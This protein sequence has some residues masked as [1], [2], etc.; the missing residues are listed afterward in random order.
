MSHDKFF[1]ICEN[2]CLVEIN[3]DSVG[4]AAQDLSNIDNKVFAE[5]A[6]E[7]GVGGGGIGSEIVP[8]ENGGTGATTAEEARI[9]LGINSG[10]GTVLYS[11]DVI[12]KTGSSH[13]IT[14]EDDIN[15]YKYIEVC[16]RRLYQQIFYTDTNHQ[17]YS[18]SGIE[19]IYVSSDGNTNV[20][21]HSIDHKY[22]S[23]THTLQSYMYRVEFSGTTLEVSEYS[24]GIYLDNS[25]QPGTTC[26]KLNLNNGNLVIYSVI[27]YK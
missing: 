2:K 9:N 10:S 8:I 20:A 16:Y 13:A 18:T 23:E 27:G 11:G 1:G 24:V 22:E 12:I 5:K 15:N 3:A 21:L 4:A 19:K 26:N 7:A 17:V 14:L 25:Y 6:T